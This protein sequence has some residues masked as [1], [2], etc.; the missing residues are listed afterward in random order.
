MFVNMGR[1]FLRGQAAVEYASIIVIVMIALIPVAYIGLT[2]IED[3]SRGSQ[4]QVT[5]SA[6][7]DASDLVFA[8]GPGAR[9]AVD[10]FIPRGTNAAKTGVS[11]KEI[12]INVYTTTGDE[13]D[14]FALARGNLTGNIT[15][16]PGRHR[17]RV[18]MLNSGTVQIS[19]P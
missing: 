3:S 11:G 15:A 17:L 4:A 13:H 19:E 2:S 7:V 9:T 8:Q 5:V 1:R 12:R 10:V 18:E 16:V 14:Y 6:L